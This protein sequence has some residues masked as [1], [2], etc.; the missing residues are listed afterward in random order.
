DARERAAPAHPVPA[1][2]RGTHGW[3]DQRAVAGPEPVGAFAAPGAAA[4][5]GHRRHAT[6]IDAGLV[7]TGGR[8]VAP[9]AGH[10]VRHLLLAGEATAAR[11]RA[12]G[13][14]LALI[15]SDG[16]PGDG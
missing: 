5:R 3:P 12:T 11:W 14:T 16:P 10:A 8:T 9:A 4:R 15:A 13:W 7:S 2:A 1:R 6:R